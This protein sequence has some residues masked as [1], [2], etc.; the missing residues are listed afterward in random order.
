EKVINDGTEYGLRRGMIAFNSEVGD[1]SLGAMYFLYRYQCGNHIIWGAQ[2]VKE[3][4]VAHRGSTVRPRFDD[5][6]AEVSRYLDRSASDEEAV[7]ATARKT[8]VGQTKDDV[9]DALFGK[10][11][12]QLSGP[13]SPGPGN[14]TPSPPSTSPSRACASA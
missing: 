2:D 3:V 10:K 8:L 12:L 6:V 9:L 11:T 13:G 14:H 4:R 5:Y 1:T 7:I